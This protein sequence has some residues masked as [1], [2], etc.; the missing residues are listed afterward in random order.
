MLAEFVPHARHCAKTSHESHR[1]GATIVPIS[2]MRTL[3]LR[4][5]DGH[6][7]RVTETRRAQKLESRS[8]TLHRVATLLSA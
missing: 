4:E 3:R 1:V 5:A 2:Q 8:D 6:L 7:L